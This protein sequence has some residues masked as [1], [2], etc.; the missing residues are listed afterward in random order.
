[1]K[2]EFIKNSMG[3]FLFNVNDNKLYFWNS[4]GSIIALEDFSGRFRFGKKMFESNE[5]SIKE[6]IVN[7]I[8][9]I[10]YIALN[11]RRENDLHNKLQLNKKFVYR[12]KDDILI[13]N[14]SLG[15][16]FSITADRVNIESEE[17]IL[18]GKEDYINDYAGCCDMSEED[19]RE[20]IEQRLIYDGIIT[21]CD[22]SLYPFSNNVNGV[23]YYY[24]SS[25]CGCLHEDILQVAPEF[26]KYIDL[27]LSEDV[28]T[29]IDLYLELNALESDDVDQVVKQLTYDIIMD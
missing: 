26:K 23:E 3:N 22:N 9:L 18:N 17:S 25:S 19:A 21:I 11:A 20:E 15:R 10:E 13:V 5:E 14:L 24:P 16:Y 6:F 27:H 4:S 12:I 8:P 1:M 29:L 2:I 7:N 28:S